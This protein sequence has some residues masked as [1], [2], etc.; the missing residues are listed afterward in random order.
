MC[1]AQ[2]W[3]GFPQPP[4]PPFQGC[5]VQTVVNTIVD[6]AHAVAADG[7]RDTSVVNIEMGEAGGKWS[8]GSWLLPNIFT[9]PDYLSHVWST[10]V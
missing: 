8:L 7:L 1:H 3:P 10:Y 5:V 2:L 6:P 4:F 9:F